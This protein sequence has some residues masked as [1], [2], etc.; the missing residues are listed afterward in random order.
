MFLK[1]KSK[2][3]KDLKIGEELELLLALSKLAKIFGYLAFTKSH[4]LVRHGT[5]YANEF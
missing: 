4:L 2:F 5:C 3:Q 1:V